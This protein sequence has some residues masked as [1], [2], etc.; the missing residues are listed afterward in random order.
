MNFAND[1]VMEAELERVR[2]ELLGSTA[3]EYRD[4]A[5][6]RQRLQEGLSGLAEHARTLATQD[7]QELV[8]RFGELGRR[9]FHL[10]A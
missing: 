9:K 1:S 10:A 2:K 6:A 3:Q 7:A 8:Q 5:S 4:S